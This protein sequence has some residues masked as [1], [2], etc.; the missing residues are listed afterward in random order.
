[1]R[2]G[3]GDPN[4]VETASKGTIWQ[5]TDG[6]GQHYINTDGSDTWVELAGTGLSLT[7]TAPLTI[8]GAAAVGDGT[9]AMRGNAK[10]DIGTKG[11]NVASAATI[12]LD[13]AT[14]DYVHVTGTTTITAVT[15]ASGIRRDVIFDGVLALTHG[16]N[17]ILPT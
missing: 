7:D 1:V 11:T 13:S 5:R 10:L 6:D 14:G 2:R 16:E 12:D 3:E 8:G 9:T 4:G 17:L 15:L